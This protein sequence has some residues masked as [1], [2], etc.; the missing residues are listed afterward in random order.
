MESVDE[1]HQLN[2]QNEDLIYYS[3]AHLQALLGALAAGGGESS[4]LYGPRSQ[5]SESHPRTLVDWRV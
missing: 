4:G 2:R 3:L 1:L 5:M